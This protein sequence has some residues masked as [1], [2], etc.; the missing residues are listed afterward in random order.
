MRKWQQVR[1][2]EPNDVLTLVDDTDP[3]PEQ[4]QVLIAPEVVGISMPDLLLCR[5]DYQST[6]SFPFTVGGELAGVVVDVPNGSPFVPGQRVMSTNVRPGGLATHVVADVA[7]TDPLPDGVRADVAAA[8]PVNYVT[9]HLAL[10]HR[11]GLRDGETVLVMGGA[12]GVGSAAIQ[13][14]LASGAR[15]LATA[16]DDERLDACRTLGAHTVIDAR[17]GDLPHQVREATGGFGADVIVDP[18]GGDVF[19][20][21]RRCVAFEG[22]IV[23][24][25]FIAGRIA[26][27]STNQLMLRSFSAVG[28]NNG[29]TMVHRPDVHRAARLACLA[30][31][32]RGQI[33]P[34]IGGRWTFD[35]A[36]AALSALAGGSVI[37]KALVELP[38][39]DP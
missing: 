34:L 7:V 15:V 38:H 33:S 21:A 19:D 10:H 16:I 18:V 20:D 11:A 5:G 8:I 1:H 36:P 37:G 35:R 24:V 26:Q 2:G 28:V 12:G 13:L 39:R 23:V 29:Q 30:L 6:N 4:G 17:A 32:A 3:Q 9:A 31:A 25:G 27:L 22:R 14:A